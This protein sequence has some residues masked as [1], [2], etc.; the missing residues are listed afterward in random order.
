MIAHRATFL[1]GYQDAAYARRFTDR[2]ARF[3]AALPAGSDDTVAAAAKSLFR[4]MAFKDEYEVGRLFADP[5][6]EAE[7]ASRFEGDYTVRY[8]LAPP[9]LPAGTDARGR[10]LKRSFGPWMG[11]GMKALARMKRLR[12]TFLD[13]FARTADRKLDRDL[14]AWFEGVLDRVERDA[15]ALGPD[16]AMKAVSLPQ[17]IRG[18]GPVRHKAADRARAEMAALLG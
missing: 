8:H 14:L 5:A 3:R 4:L 9:M 16:V 1:T 2:I 13:P 7:I 10:P 6:F 17:D 12:G 18:Y 15:A 11:R